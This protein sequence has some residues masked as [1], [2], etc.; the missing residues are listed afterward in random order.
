MYL[1][2]IIIFG[3]QNRSFHETIISDIT[4]RGSLKLTRCSCQKK[5]YETENLSAKE[6]W[7][8]KQN[9][10]LSWSFLPPNLRSGVLCLFSSVCGGLDPIAIQSNDLL[11]NPPYTLTKRLLGN[12]TD[13]QFPLASFWPSKVTL[14]LFTLTFH[15]NTGQ[16]QRLCC[17]A[18]ILTS[19]RPCLS[20]PKCDHGTL[21][22]KDYGISQKF[23]VLRMLWAANFKKIIRV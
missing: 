21:R 2:G 15:L 7:N 13:L 9:L 5:V 16:I 4:E 17:L 3:V 10:R 22:M 19:S 8:T 6:R 12:L 23:L 11:G 18:L 20:H 1:C 14:N